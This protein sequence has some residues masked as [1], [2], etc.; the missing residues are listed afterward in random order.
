[1]KASE[2]ELHDGKGFFVIKGLNHDTLTA[3][4]SSLIYLGITSYI[5]DKKGIQNF[6]GDVIGRPQFPHAFPEGG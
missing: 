4:E 1:M 5:G 2:K 3:A 6:D